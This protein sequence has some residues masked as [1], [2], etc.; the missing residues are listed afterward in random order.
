MQQPGQDSPP[1]S[2][3]R[4]SAIEVDLNSGERILVF[5]DKEV[6]LDLYI[7]I[8]VDNNFGVGNI[9]RFENIVRQ[10]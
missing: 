9:P 7:S 3:P 2:L 6:R 1:G 10:E 5:A 8:Y 4:A